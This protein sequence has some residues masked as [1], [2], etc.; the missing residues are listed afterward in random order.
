MSASPHIGASATTTEAPHRADRQTNVDLS[1]VV[2]CL[3]EEENIVP[4]LEQLRAVLT[5]ID[6]VAEVV[7]VDD[8]S[9]DRTFEL[10][11]QFAA[12]ARQAMRISVV[13]RQLHRRGYGAVV[14]YGVAS[15]VGRY[16]IF[17]SADA[18][19][20][21]NLIPEFYRRMESGAAMVQCSRYLHRDDAHTIPFKYKFYQFFY[22]LGVRWL[23]GIAIL[24]STYAFKMFRRVELLGVGLTQNRFSISPEITFKV[25]LNGGRI[26]YVAAGQGIR[27]KGVSKFY[28]RKEAIGY[29]YVLARAFLHRTGF[30]LW[31]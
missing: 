20:P 2:P 11:M 23:L 27:T 13:R 28:F 16:C 7:V 19:D 9:D 10:A 12:Q 14:R 31:F 30:I 4:I 1:I 15:A 24:D 18:V 26:D 25:L 8:M 5:G 17:V 21:I 22:R 29:M 3:N 6:F